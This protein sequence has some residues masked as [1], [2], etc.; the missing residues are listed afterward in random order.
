MVRFLLLL[1]LLVWSLGW[2][3]W[4]AV[5]EFHEDA[6]LELERQ[7]AVVDSLVAKVKEMDQL[8]AQLEQLSDLVAEVERD[9]AVRFEQAESLVNHVDELARRGQVELEGQLK[10]LTDTMESSSSSSSGSNSE[11][12]FVLSFVVTPRS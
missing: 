11:F 9:T 6:I 1:R 7:G 12:A 2:A 4:S 10:Q 8:L 3:P 5:F